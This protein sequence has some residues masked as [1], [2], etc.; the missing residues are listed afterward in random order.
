MGS[1][2]SQKKKKLEWIGTRNAYLL[3]PDIHDIFYNLAQRLPRVPDST[4]DEFWR[5]YPDVVAEIR[6]GWEE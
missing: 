4:L 1:S 3:E 2:Q 6:Q 5:E